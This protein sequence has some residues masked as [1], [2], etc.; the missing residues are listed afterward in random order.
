[1]LEDN[2]MQLDHGLLLWATRLVF[3]VRARLGQIVSKENE[4]LIFFTLGRVPRAE[5]LKS[6]CDRP[7]HGAT[8][9]DDEDVRL[10][11]MQVKLA[12]GHPQM[13]RK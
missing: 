3:P 7:N 9:D 6:G 12:E 4:S 2:G 13:A 10:I 8:N 1:M 11:E 5:R